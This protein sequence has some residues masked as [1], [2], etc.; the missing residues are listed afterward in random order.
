MKVLVKICESIFMLIFL[1]TSKTFLLY[2]LN[3]KGG[4][5]KIIS[6]TILITLLFFSVFTLKVDAAFIT[7]QG[8]RISSKDYAKL[9]ELGIQDFEIQNLS[10]SEIS[11]YLLLDYNQV[12][13]ETSYYEEVYSVVDGET[14]TVSNKLTK[15]VYEAKVAAKQEVNSIS[16][17]TTPILA[18]ATVT[19][20]N[21]TAY[22]TMT[23]TGSYST[24]TQKFFIRNT[25][26]WDMTPLVRLSDII[27][28]S[29]TSNVGASMV[30]YNGNQ[31]ADYKSK[32]VYGTNVYD[33]RAGGIQSVTTFHSDYYNIANCLNVC[34]ETEL[35]GIFSTH[36]LPDDNLVFYY[37]YP[38]SYVYGYV[39]LSM[40]SS[41]EGYFSPKIPNLIFESFHGAYRHMIDGGTVYLGSVGLSPI[42]PYISYTPGY[43]SNPPEFDSTQS[44]QVNVYAN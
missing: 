27:S 33:S 21:S 32:L 39:V 35:Y 7:L 24:S 20:T 4:F 36:N 37:N 31:V 25:V 18:S 43:Q 26:H 15:S 6:K 11:E 28:I 29:H 13:S 30:L 16:E 14:T 3:C 10:K 1:L 2:Y 41:L 34:F 22:K 8:I 44:A 42:A 12:F 5:M 40:Y 19:A 17:Q 23:V 38:Y 9:V